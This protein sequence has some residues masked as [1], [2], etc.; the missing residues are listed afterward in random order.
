MRVLDMAAAAESA[1]KIIPGGYGV[2]AIPALPNKNES[3]APIEF[4]DKYVTKF[5]YNPGEK[6]SA[7]LAAAKLPELLGEENTGHAMYNYKRNYTYKNIPT[8]LKSQFRK[9]LETGELQFNKAS[10]IAHASKIPMVR[11]PNLGIDIL[12]V[13]EDSAAIEKLRKVPVE[14]VLNQMLKVLRQLKYLNE[15]SAYIHGDVRDT[16]IVIN[17]ETGTTTLIDFDVLTPEKDIFKFKNMYLYSSPPELFLTK[18][19]DRFSS[20][21]SSANT[22]NELNGI[23]KTDA[24]LK[25]MYIEYYDKHKNIQEYLFA[26]DFKPVELTAVILNN[27]NEMK[28]KMSRRIPSLS[29]VFIYSVFPTIDAFGFGLSFLILFKSLYEPAFDAFTMA[30]SEDDAKNE[31]Y[32]L[33]TNDDGTPR[34]THEQIHVIFT[35]IVDILNILKNMYSLVL[36]SRYSTSDGY[37]ML[38]THVDTI[39]AA[40]N[41][42]AGAGASTRRRRRRGGARTLRRK[43]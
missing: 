30:K 11:M 39:L 2:V 20:L 26:K 27:L 6:N 9:S 17:P 33:L 42:P 8:S 22:V 15:S 23:L 40:V 38:K 25:K 28:R 19:L 16:N 14:V 10:Q 1:Y 5:F 35:N 43:K 29:K 18:Y 36:K 41:P 3:D 21:T 12:N 37:Y 4:G 34:Y 32:T 31:L 7:M 24:F 13:T